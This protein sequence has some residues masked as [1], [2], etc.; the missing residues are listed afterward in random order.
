MGQVRHELAHPLVCGAECSH[1]AISTDSADT[2]RVTPL[3]RDGGLDNRLW[4]WQQ[5]AQAEYW[6][7]GTVLVG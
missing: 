7:N 1:N 2:L 5:G 3:A 4:S 6:S